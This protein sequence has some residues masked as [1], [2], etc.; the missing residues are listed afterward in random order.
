MD[1]CAFN[2]GQ[3]NIQAEAEAEAEAEDAVEA[4]VSCLD[5]ALLLEEANELCFIE[6]ARF[7]H[8]AIRLPFRA[9]SFAVVSLM[10][11]L[12]LLLLDLLEASLAQ[13]AKL[14]T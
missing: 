4:S 2:G 6:A 1:L 14:K 11:P 7:P 8:R 5:A 10:L 13:N 9:V 3:N 12:L